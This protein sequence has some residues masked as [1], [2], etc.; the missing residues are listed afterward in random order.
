MREYKPLLEHWLREAAL[1]SF[2]RGCAH[3][4]E[5]VAAMRE[6]GSRLN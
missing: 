5:L 2:V 6:T 1:R 4:G 3:A